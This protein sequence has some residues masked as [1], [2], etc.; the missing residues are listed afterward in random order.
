ISISGSGSNDNLAPITFTITP[1][2]VG[3]MLRLSPGSVTE[4][5]S[6][7][8]ENSFTWNMGEEPMNSFIPKGGFVVDGNKVSG[9]ALEVHDGERVVRAGRL[10]EKTYVDTIEG[11]EGGEGS[12]FYRYDDGVIE[13]STLRKIITFPVNDSL[14]YAL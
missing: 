10:V 12:G 3:M 2:M 8:Y 7:G 14:K 13:N 4:E 11:V 9:V 5:P 1:E 6:E